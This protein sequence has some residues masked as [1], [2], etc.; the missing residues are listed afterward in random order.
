MCLRAAL[1][2]RGA[3]TKKLHG[4]RSN[5]ASLQLDQQLLN[6][7]Q[8]TA[9]QDTALQDT[10][11]VKGD[12][13]GNVGSCRLGDK[14]LQQV[15]REF[16]ERLGVT[17]F[18][19]SVGWLRGWKGRCQGN[20]REGKTGGRK[21][22]KGGGRRKKECVSVQVNEKSE[23]DATTVGDIADRASARSEKCRSLLSTLT[24]QDKRGVALLQN[25]QQDSTCSHR[26]YKKTDGHTLCCAVEDGQVHFDYS[27]PEHNYSSCR[28][29][30][31]PN[32]VTT[33]TILLNS[34]QSHQQQSTGAM[35]THVDA[36]TPTDLEVQIEDLLEGVALLQ[37]ERVGLDLEEADDA[38]LLV[39]DWSSELHGD[40]RDS[41]LEQSN[42][43]E[44]IPDDHTAILEDEQFSSFNHRSFTHHFPFIPHS[45]FSANWCPPYDIT[46]D[47][48]NTPFDGTATK[49]HTPM[50]DFPGVK[51]Q[52]YTHNSGGGY[53]T[54]SK[55]KA[56]SRMASKCDGGVKGGAVGVATTDA[57]NRSTY[58]ISPS[59]FL[60]TG[61]PPPMSLGG[62][63]LLA[64]PPP[65]GAGGVVSSPRGGLLANRLF[66]PIFPD[67]PEIVFHEIQLGPLHTLQ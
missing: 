11:G 63:S 4:G 23:G 19:A 29:L 27:T 16:A 25:S 2:S 10:D 17:G 59:T 35:P 45:L 55:S 32:P 39:C 37:K 65:P 13:D 67:E 7:V 57:N 47:A 22:G 58:C 49:H 18:K 20:R 8:D 31:I 44:L 54:R 12:G 46:V 60:E 33:P 40:G 36:T 26:D 41:A 14:H 3:L 38:P 24:S 66:Q 30:A 62:V 34:S 5:S 61:S 43:E 9:L 42:S 48:F 64:S 50:S 1:L 6:Y 28:S 53:Q 56:E 51:G 52:G 21:R 15:A